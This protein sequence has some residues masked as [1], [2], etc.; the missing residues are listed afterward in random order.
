MRIVKTEEQQSEKYAKS[1]ILVNA[2][3]EMTH[4]WSVDIL[5][6]LLQKHLKASVVWQINHS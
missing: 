6:E 4:V 5:V 2:R 1:I 3:D